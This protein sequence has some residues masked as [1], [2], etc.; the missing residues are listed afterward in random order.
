VISVERH[1][2]EKLHAMCRDF[3]DRDNTRVRD[4]VDVVILIERGLLEPSAVAAAATE[5][6]AERDSSPPPPT[7]AH[8]PTSWRDRYQAL[9]ATH[10]MR[11]TTF[12]AAV[13]LVDEL[14]N[15]MFHDEEA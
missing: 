3:G 14:W 12:P 1:A 9:A 7:L 8:A 13:A 2:A 4:L 11:A 15:D 5:V 6:W 10:A